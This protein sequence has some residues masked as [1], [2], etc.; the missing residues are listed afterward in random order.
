MSKKKEWGLRH[1]IMELRFNADKDT[2]FE[3]MSLSRLIDLEKDLSE[4]LKIWKENDAEIA[5]GYCLALETA[6]GNVPYFNCFGKMTQEGYSRCMGNCEASMWCFRVTN[7]SKPCP[8][9]FI[10]NPDVKHVKCPACDC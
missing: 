1:I 10:M 4:R 5:K 3:R 2:L 6:L 7:W 9:K 8:S